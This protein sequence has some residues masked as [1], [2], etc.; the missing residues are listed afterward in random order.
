MSL[1]RV[2][3][4]FDFEAT[5]GSAH[6]HSFAR[7]WYISLQ[8]QVGCFNHIVVTLVADKLERQ[9]LQEVCFGMDVQRQS[10]MQQ[11]NSSYIS[12]IG[13][14]SSRGLGGRSMHKV[15]D[16]RHHH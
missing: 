8:K 4:G 6:G 10:E 14:H 9:W 16:V 12:T 11:H 15:Y 3:S 13:V 7:L 1:S 5:G 2:P